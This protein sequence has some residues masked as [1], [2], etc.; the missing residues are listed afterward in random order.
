VTALPTPIRHSLTY[1]RE[2]ARLHR[3]ARASFNALELI[4]LFPGWYGSLAANRSPLADERPW[5]AMAAI[6][7]L[8]QHV[9]RQARV[10]EYGSGGSTL[11]FAKRAHSV[12]SVEHDPVWGRRVSAALQARGH[13]HCRLQIIEPVK[14]DGQLTADPSDPHTYATSDASLRAF[15]FRDYAASVDDYP[16]Q[17]FDWILIDGRARPA[18]F[19]HALPKL[20]RGGWL[21]WDNTERATYARAL[22]SAD[23]KIERIEF[24]GPVIGNPEFSQTTVLRRRARE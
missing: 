14:Q 17:Y 12:H 9:T 20:A 11:F 3:E 18:C 8:E 16:D 21:V 2:S 1:A 10:F 7:Y 6:R 5:L 13:T 19:A 4:G 15:S 23:A 24:Y 22:R